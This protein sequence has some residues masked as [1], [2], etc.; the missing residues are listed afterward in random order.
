MSKMNGEKK[1]I[2]KPMKVN[3]GNEIPHSSP[4]FRYNTIMNKSIVQSELEKHTLSLPNEMQLLRVC[5]CLRSSSMVFILSFAVKSIV[6]IPSSNQFQLNP[7][8]K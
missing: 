4:H 5:E 1:T 3:I 7:L 6:L 8:P 2:K